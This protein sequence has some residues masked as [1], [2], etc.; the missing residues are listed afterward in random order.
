MNKYNHEGYPDPT[1]YGAF[2]NIEKEIK[3]LQKPRPMIYICSPYAGN[4]ERNVENARKYSRFAV[5]QGVMPITPHLLF[6]QF[7]NDDDYRERQLGMGFGNTILSKC[8]EVW[9]F[10]TTIS[11]GMKAEIKSAKWHNKVIKYFNE[12]CEEVHR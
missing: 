10:G 9:V 3:E 6:T 11:V 4:V 8:Q 7:L 1:A 2:V 5:K 12:D